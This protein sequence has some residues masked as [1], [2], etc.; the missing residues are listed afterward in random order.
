[1]TF[2]LA[3]LAFPLLLVLLA[4]GVGL[5]VERAAGFAIP[6]VLLAPLGFAGIVVATQLTTWS[7]AIAPATPYVV[8][9]LA[10]A[11][12]LLGG[13][14][15]L[16]RLRVRRTGWWWA[17]GAG[18]AA[19]VIGAGPVLLA[20][21]VTFPGYLL[22]TTGSVQLMGAQRLI[23]HG[24][25][26]NVSDSG[27][28][29]QLHGYFGSGY[30]SGAHSAL[31]GVGH[32]VGVDLLWLYAPYLA[33]MLA[34]AALVLTFLARHA[35]LPRPAAALAGC[36]SAVPALVYAYALQGS[37]KEIA[38]L[39]TLLLLGALIVLARETAGAGPR[40]VVPLA[41]AGAAGWGTIGLA[42]TP[43]LALVALAVLVLGLPALP[44]ARAA[45]ARAAVLATA[46]FAAALVL[47]ALPTVAPL[48]TSLTQATNVTNGNAAA[49]T[50][51]GNLLR[52]LLKVQALGVWLGGSHRGDPED[53]RTTYLLIG[54]VLV[55][56]GLGI[57]WLVRRRRWAV[58]AYVALSV[59]VWLVLT[60]RATTWTAA[61]LLVLL[62]PVLLLVAC[63]GAFGRLGARRLEGVLLAAAIAGGVL[64]SDAWLYHETS[65]APTARF[66]E[67]RDVGRRFAGQGPALTPDFDE[68]A[69][70]L[71][72]DMAPDGPGNAR[73][74]QPWPGVGYGHTYDLD[75]LP[76]AL[77]DRFQT[78]VVR[79]SPFKSRPPSPF[80]LAWQGTWY[81][82]WRRDRTRPAP[83]EHLGLGQGFQVAAR[84]SCAAL[85]AL[86]ARAAHAGERTLTV[87]P[88][89]RFAL[90]DLGR[91]QLRGSV[92]YG[93]IGGL[94][95]LGFVG[96]ATVTLR[97]HV[98]S[99]GTYRLWVEGGAG[100]PLRATLDGRPIGE[101]RDQEGGEGNVM[102]YGSRRLAA[103]LHT[104]VIARGGGSL[105]PGDAAAT[106]VQAVVLEPSSATTGTP[107][108]IPLAAWP[109]LCHMTLDWV[110]RP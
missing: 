10:L 29:L 93:P 89:P 12:A 68:Y 102:P 53:L 50:D 46:A 21:R 41:L 80:A 25:S 18:L 78:I 11:G 61:K 27:Y 85:R 69:L 13:R 15:A 90:A 95:A 62:S 67:L 96:P 47:F 103:G 110:E 109:R 77:V 97:I 17:G 2:P 59:L 84:P 70:Y 34:L 44:G 48:G 56:V 63:V 23:A 5:L 94:P 51:P 30:P 104:I 35:G 98:P 16:A 22:D 107:R 99:A 1:M 7:G 81:D 60:P 20:G 71:L 74:V 92:S 8:I 72:R 52:P 100:R 37:I 64:A 88:R 58:L 40:G 75:A 76:A 26:W 3:V 19:Y 39:P 82:V 14:G 24:R 38:L 9:A 108:R 28:G 55:A 31:G 86:A 32:L 49:A 42:F 101:A 91:A 66:Q 83:L 4:L 45:A 6:A 54:V 33:T 73:K 106:F 36:I 43:W 57:V 65:L 87:A 79:R 105:R